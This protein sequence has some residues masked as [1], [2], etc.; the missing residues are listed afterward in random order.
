DEMA[1]TSVFNRAR[2]DFY[3]GNYDEALERVNK[4]LGVMPGDPVM[5]EFRALVLFAQGNFK[6]A[7]ATIHAVLAVGPGWDWTTM[8]SVY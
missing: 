4:A 1:A 3:A 6:E 5:N 7:A 2:E 8:T